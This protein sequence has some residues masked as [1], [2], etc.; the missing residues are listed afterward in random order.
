MNVSIGSEAEEQVNPFP[1]VLTKIGLFEKKFSFANCFST[2]QT[3]SI[4]TGN[5]IKL[6]NCEAWEASSS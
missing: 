5:L 3:I 2:I 6:I 4:H 1:R